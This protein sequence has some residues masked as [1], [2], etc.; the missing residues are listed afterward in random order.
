MADRIQLRRDTAANWT[1]VNPILAQGELGVETD[2]LKFKLGDG[3]TA[4]NSISNY[5]I[6]TGRYALLA[7]PT[8][9]GTPA[10]P[11][12]SAG[13]N[14]TQLATTAFVVAERSS[15]ATLT[16]KT[17]TAPVISSPTGIVKADVGL[18]NV[19]NTSDASKPVST[20]QQTALNLKADLAGATFSGTV[21]VPTATAGTNST[22]AASTAFVIAERS[23]IAPLTNKTITDIVYTITDGASVD[24]NPS[25][26]GVQFWTL[27]ANRTATASSFASGQSMILGIND[28]TG[29]SLTFPSIT[30]TKQGGGGTAPTL[31]TT[32]WTWIVLW[33]ANSTLYGS[34][35]GDA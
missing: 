21:Y 6:N 8:F 30:W 10:A 24:L 4:W 15:T 25:N 2:T 23:N 13:T 1:S 14:T 31:N 12:A 5:I 20:V 17:L 33:K 27:G 19:D 11:T 32:A 29:Y 28:G 34:Y 9:T 3:T 16:N 22:Q 18:G 7:S 26:G 35:L